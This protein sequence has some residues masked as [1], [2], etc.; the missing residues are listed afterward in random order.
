MERGDARPIRKNTC[1]LVKTRL[2]TGY[3][4][5]QG[6]LLLGRNNSGCCFGTKTAQITDPGYSLYL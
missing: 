2:E 3:R 1:H 6:V 4:S 5:G